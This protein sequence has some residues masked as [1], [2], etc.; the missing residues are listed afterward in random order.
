[1]LPN[2]LKD[3]TI[4]HNGI[5]M[6]N[7]NLQLMQRD[8][9]ENVEIYWCCRSQTFTL[10]RVKK[11]EIE[12]SGVIKKQCIEYRCLI[13]TLPNVSI[14]FNERWNNIDANGEL[15]QPANRL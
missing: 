9:R 3:L 1:M 7:G 14:R 13:D 2:I 8:T 10:G 6:N 5:L 4:R 15:G 11:R 12:R